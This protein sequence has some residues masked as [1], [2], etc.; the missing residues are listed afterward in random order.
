LKGV[1]GYGDRG[2]RGD[3]PDEM[4]ATLCFM[5]HRFFGFVYLNVGGFLLQAGW[6]ACVANF[7]CLF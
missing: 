2:I 5:L 7:A 6:C 4:G 1:L 3:A